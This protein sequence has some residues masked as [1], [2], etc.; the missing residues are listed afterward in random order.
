MLGFLGRE[1]FSTTMLA[2]VA[3]DGRESTAPGL[4]LEMGDEAVSGRFESSSR[5]RV[6]SGNARAGVVSRSRDER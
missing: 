5:C 3:V 6:D 2:E 4:G 1:K